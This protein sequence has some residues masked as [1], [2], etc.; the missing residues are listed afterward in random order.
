LKLGV[1]IVPEKRWPENSRRWAMVE[2]L[3]FDSAWTY[4]H[5]WW[6]SLRDNA[7]FSS[8]PLVA[9]AASI[10]TRVR[11]GIMVAS[12]NFRHPVLV[13]KDAIAIDDI[14]GGR[15]V[16]GIGAGAAKA[17]DAE[18]LGGE[19]LSGPDRFARFEEFVKLTDRL[20]R[21]PNTTFDGRFYSARD[22]RMIPGCTGKPRL[23]LAIGAWS[24]KSLALAAHYGDA[25]VTPGPADWLGDHTLDECVATVAAQLD[26]LKRACERNGR[27]VDELDRILISTGMGGNPLESPDKCL[28]IAERFAAVGMTHLVIHW[29]RESGVYAGDPRV[30][31]EI[32]AS[33][34]PQIRAL[35]TGTIPEP[36][37]RR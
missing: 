12:P 27:D 20:L 32:A 16:L 26:Q 33:A 9:A 2:E 28:E 24:P 23:P 29:P 25:W 30:V 14:S 6:R 5:I 31:E 36:A 15:F 1:L 7:W 10:T 4:D 8:I 13:A 19:P 22:A 11:V 37:L 34:L 3:G 18:V 17:G 35:P 21:E